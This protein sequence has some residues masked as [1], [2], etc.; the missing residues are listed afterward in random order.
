M[1]YSDGD[2]LQLRNHSL[3]LNPRWRRRTAA[4]AQVSQVRHIASTTWPPLSAN[5]RPTKNCT[6]CSL[7]RTLHSDSFYLKKVGCCLYYTI[8]WCS[9][10]WRVAAGDAFLPSVHNLLNELECTSRT[11]KKKCSTYIVFIVQAHRQATERCIERDFW[12]VPYIHYTRLHRLC[13]TV[14]DDLTS[15]VPVTEPIILHPWMSLY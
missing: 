4:V 12:A 11:M 14:H 10:C 7:V 9:H 1:M 8:A 5:V 6:S 3:L 15:C 2:K 13:A